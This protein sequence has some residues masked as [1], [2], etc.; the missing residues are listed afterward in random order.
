MRNDT[1]LDL[2]ECGGDDSGRLIPM[3]GAAAWRLV[4]P[5]AASPDPVLRE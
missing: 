3:E 2:R 4:S 1:P 5:E